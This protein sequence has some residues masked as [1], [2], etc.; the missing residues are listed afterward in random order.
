MLSLVLALTVAAPFTTPTRIDELRVEGL[1]ITQVATV[2]RELPFAEG[3]EV[4]PELWD[5]FETRLWNLGVFSRV[6]VTLVQEEQRT[7][8][9]ATLE[10]RFP[11]GPVVRANFGGGQ[12]FLWLGVGHV[13][14][15]G[16]ALEGRAVYE[17]FGNQNGF[18]VRLFD[19]RLFD[20]RIGAALEVEWLSR[21]L[22]EFVARRAAVRAAV[23]FNAPGTFDDRFRL[24]VRVEGNSDET[25]V[26]N[27]DLPPPP[28]NSK[29]LFAGLYLRLGRLDIDRL[30][31]MQGFVEVRGDFMATT[32][33][34]HP[35]G[36]MTTIEAQY[37][38][39]LGERFN[40][41]FR[42]LGG[43][44]RNARPQ[45]RFYIG[46][47]DRVRGYL[48]SEI[49]AQAFATANVELRV[50]AFDSTWFAVM[51]IAFVDGGIAAR[52]TNET[53]P[54]ASAGVGLRLMVPRMVRFGARLEVAFP[55]AATPLT[56]AFKPGINFGIWH[57]F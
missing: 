30:R 46:G 23:D 37:F 55:F 40:V 13:N 52:D 20:K 8:V 11:I 17:R 3:D 39:K 45:D 57:F 24:G 1:W 19:P 14:L 4:T 22:P 56:P 44:E 31:F 10:D 28:P 50:V 47:L 54:L 34:S 26:S 36:G 7:I 29:G 5:L 49:R 33:P 42:A 25:F 35:I 15:F 43:F 2:R 41:G 53:Q 18:F 27:P 51:P 6:E 21:P 48:Y 32:D 38:W 16:R 12:F 9:K